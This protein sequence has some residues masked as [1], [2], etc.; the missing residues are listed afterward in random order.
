MH[1][2]NAANSWVTNNVFDNWPITALMVQEAA[3]NLIRGNTFEN[4]PYNGTGNQQVFLV[5]GASDNVLENNIF[6]DADPIKIE[7]GSNGN[8]IAYNFFTGGD[9]RSIFYHG[10]Y[11]HENLSE[12]NDLFSRNIAAD[13]Y[14]GRQGPRNTVYRQPRGLPEAVLGCQR[15]RGRPLRSE[16]CVVRLLQ[17]RLGLQRRTGLR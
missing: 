3:R 2:Q 17:H 6:N 14:W 16:G 13:N 11:N 1:I 12:G 4:S 8:V 9:T 15:R 5:R 10:T 7:Q